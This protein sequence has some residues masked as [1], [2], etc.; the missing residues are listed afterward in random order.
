MPLRATVA[1]LVLP[2]VLAFALPVS[3]LAGAG[4]L[5]PRHPAGLALLIAGTLGLASCIREFHVEGKGTLAPWDPPRFLVRTGLFRY[6]RNPMYLSV[7]LVLLGWAAAYGS[8]PLLVY[9][10][11]VV[12]GFHLRVVLG[13]EPWLRRKYGA[14]WQAYCEMVPRWLPLGKGPP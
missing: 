2:G 10:A 6:T 11:A 3:Y 13:E 8:L 12:I 1:F 9:A 7:A 14:Q 4:P 5:E